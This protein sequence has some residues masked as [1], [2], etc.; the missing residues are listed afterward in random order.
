MDKDDATTASEKQDASDEHNKP[1]RTSLDQLPE[2][3]HPGIPQ[4]GGLQLNDQ[5]DTA[6]AK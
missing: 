4:I 5:P 2:D 3:P 6:N 1:C